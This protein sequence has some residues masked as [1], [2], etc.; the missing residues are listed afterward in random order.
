MEAESHPQGLFLSVPLNPFPGT[1]GTFHTPL[2]AQRLSNVMKNVMKAAGVDTSVYKG[3]SG[4]SAG[5][6]AATAKGVDLLHVMVT[7]RWSSFKTFKKF[8]L[9][10]RLTE[11]QR[12][13]ARNQD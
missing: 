5:S 3:G 4:R 10:V 9:R 6:S 12:C 2:G 13:E 1:T 11:Q 7:A 8:Y